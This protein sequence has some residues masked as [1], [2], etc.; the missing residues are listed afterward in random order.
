MTIMKTLTSCA[1]AAILSSSTAYAGVCGPDR[2]ADLPL[3]ERAKAAFL[4]SEYREF[5]GI[6]GDYFPDLDQNFNNYFGQ[7]QVVFPN[8]FD[9]CETV[10]Q[11]RE[12]PGFNQDLVFF[13][14]NGSPAPIALLLVSVT[15]EGEE[16]L[17][18]FTYNTSISDVVDDLN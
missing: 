5:V 14:P 2:E 9:R 11:R 15:I 7:L 18:E 1:C 4:A 16:R 13:F 8:G 3:L 17:I 12:A 10:L 6:A